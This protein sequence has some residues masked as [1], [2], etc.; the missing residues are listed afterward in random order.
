M[1]RGQ[2]VSRA[3][4]LGHPHGVVEWLL[5]VEEGGGWPAAGREHIYI[6]VMYVCISVVYMYVFVY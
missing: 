1:A 4:E 5:G 6:Y 3:Y 2:H